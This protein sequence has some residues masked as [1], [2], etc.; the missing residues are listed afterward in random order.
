MVSVFLLPNSTGKNSFLSLQFW[1]LMMTLT[2]NGWYV[3]LYFLKAERPTIWPARGPPTTIK[4]RWPLP[5]RYTH[6]HIA[7]ERSQHTW[8]KPSKELTLST[9]STITNLPKRDSNPDAA[10]S[11][12]PYPLM[13][14]PTA[15]G[16]TYGLPISSLWCISFLMNQANHSLFQLAIRQSTE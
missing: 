15:E 13:A 9:R 14:P 3:F 1:S 5:T 16:S 12:Q 8:G 11:T 4:G 6:T 7:D 2:R 10:F